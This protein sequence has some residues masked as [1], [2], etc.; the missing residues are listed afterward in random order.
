VGP[1]SGRRARPAPGSGRAGIN[2]ATSTAVYA[3]RIARPPEREPR[4]V[5]WEEADELRSWMPDYVARIVPVAILT[6]LRRGEILGLR[7]R[8][9]DFETGS[10]SV[11]AQ[12]QGGERVRAK[13]AA[14]RRTVDVGPAT[15]KLL[16]EQQL[17]RA[18]NPE[19]LLFPT[20]SGKPWDAPTSSPASTSR[21]PAT[22]GS[23]S[24]PSTTCATPG[25]R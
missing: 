15:L 9:V 18:P 16:R 2:A 4:F 1:G 13:T 8:D 7:D 12:D 23:R 3:V 19:G 20:R 22:P 10:I 5:T 11:F 14:S 21:P 6:L 25:L 24:S 17:A